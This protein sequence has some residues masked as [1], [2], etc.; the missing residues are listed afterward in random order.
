MPDLLVKSVSDAD[1]KKLRLQAARHGHSMQEELRTIIHNG[2][3]PSSG[4]SFYQALKEA[5]D[6][7]EDDGFTLPERHVPRHAPS[8]E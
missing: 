3:N 2:V 8:F 4:Q 5:F 6:G 7:L 1:K